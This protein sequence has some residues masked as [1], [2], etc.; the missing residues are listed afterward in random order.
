MGGPSR[1]MIQLGRGDGGGE[2]AGRGEYIGM[3]LEAMGSGVEEGHKDSGRWGT[4][5]CWNRWMHLRT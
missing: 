3:A 4:E 5:R 1:L 2:R